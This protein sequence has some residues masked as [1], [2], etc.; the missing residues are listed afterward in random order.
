MTVTCSPCTSH[1]LLGPCSRKG[2]RTCMWTLALAICPTFC[3]S[4][5]MSDVDVSD[6]TTPHN[7]NIRC[8]CLERGCI[9]DV[10]YLVFCW[11]MVLVMVRL[12]SE[13]RVSNFIPFTLA[14]PIPCL[15]CTPLHILLFWSTLALKSP[16]KKILSFLGIRPKS[17]VYWLVEGILGLTLWW[18]GWCISTKKCSKVILNQGDMACH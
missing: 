17:F 15:P 6:V 10:L 7:N 3:T 4:H 18:Q 16:S 13:Q 1:L 12:C 11:K 5:G 9:H 2:G 8:Q 14:W